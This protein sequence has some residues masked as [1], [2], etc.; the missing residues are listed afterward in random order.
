MTSVDFLAN[1][2]FCETRRC[3]INDRLVG[4]FFAFCLFP[5][6][7]EFDNANVRTLVK[8]IYLTNF[9]DNLG[10]LQPDRS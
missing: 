7:G 9:R 10:I 5:F 3:T 6:N 4:S 8:A 2:V 1:Q